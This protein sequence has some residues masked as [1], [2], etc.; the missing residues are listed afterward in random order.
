MPQPTATS[1]PAVFTDAT[2]TWDTDYGTMVLEQNGSAVTGT[3]ATDGGVILDATLKGRTLT[4]FWVEDASAADCGSAKDGR[5]FWGRISFEFDED[6]KSFKGK[7]LWCDQDPTANWNGIRKATS[8]TTHFIAV[9][10]RPVGGTANTLFHYSLEYWQ[11]GGDFKPLSHMPGFSPANIVAKCKALS[12]RFQPK[13]LGE[14]E[15]LARTGWRVWAGS[16]LVWVNREVWISEIVYT[17]TAAT[18]IMPIYTGNAADVQARW[19]TITGIA[20]GYPWAEQSG[21]SAGPTFSQWPQSMY[22][23]LQT[24]SNTFVRHLVTAS[25]LTMTEMS[26]PHPGNNTPSQNGDTYL[27][28]PLTM[29]SEHS[30][31]APGTPPKPKPPGTPP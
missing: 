29:Y 15:L 30:P 22:K 9:A 28:A 31:W 24:N 3:Y 27:G 25:G 12:P 1:V 26:E 18:R 13:R 6:F 4:G 20:T 10:D 8:L 14:V 7:W 19:A 2:G 17:G 23:S 11:C 16:G 5:N 21:F